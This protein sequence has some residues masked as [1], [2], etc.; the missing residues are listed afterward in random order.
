MALLAELDEP[1]ADPVVAPIDP[2]VH[3]RLELERVYQREY[4]D[5]VGAARLMVGGSTAAAEDIVQDVFATIYGLDR[6]LADREQLAGYVY[7]SVVNACR[8]S[9]RL[10]ARRLEIV[11]A[12]AVAMAPGTRAADADA[13]AVAVAAAIASLPR[14]QREAVVCHYLLGLTHAETADVLG[15]RLGTVKT[16]L[17]RGRHHLASVL[18]EENP[19]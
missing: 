13:D 16:H 9:A 17:K 6:L 2:L 8:T 5:L 19:A 7:R 15:A 1:D 4:G 11:Q 12:N 3:Q 18:G 10:D 14:K